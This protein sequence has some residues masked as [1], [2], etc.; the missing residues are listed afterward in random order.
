MVA[1]LAEE[2]DGVLEIGRTAYHFHD[3]LG[4]ALANVRAALD[5][6]ASIFDSSA[7]GTGGCPFAPGAPGNLAT[8]AL[9]S[10]L[11]SMGLKTGVDSGKLMIAS[12][13]LRD[14]LKLE[15]RANW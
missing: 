7:G 2:L 11:S 15:R 10:M 14:R 13:F 12:D 5:S 6:G 1:G 9:C 8:E 3:T 4:R